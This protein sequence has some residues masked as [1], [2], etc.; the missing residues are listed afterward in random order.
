VVE[1]TV[2]VISLRFVTHHE[3]LVNP[4]IIGRLAPS[5]LNRIAHGFCSEDLV[6]EALEVLHNQ[7]GIRRED[8]FIQTKS[9]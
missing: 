9:A 4:N 7:H 3:Q 1:R 6:G 2:N 8:L 5:L